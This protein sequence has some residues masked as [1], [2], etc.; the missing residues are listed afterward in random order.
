MRFMDES[1]WNEEKERGLLANIEE[2]KQAERKLEEEY[3]ES[4][5]MSELKEVIVTNKEHVKRGTLIAASDGDEKAIW[6]GLIQIHENS[7]RRRNI[8][9][10]K[11]NYKETGYKNTQNGKKVDKELLN[12]GYSGE[13]Q[14]VTYWKRRN[15]TQEEGK[16]V[17]VVGIADKAKA[18]D[19]WNVFNKAEKVKDIVLPR[20]RDKFGNR[21]GFVKTNS[22]VEAMKINKRMNGTVF[23]GC[24]LITVMANPKAPRR[25]MNSGIKQKVVPVMEK[26]YSNM[27]EQ[28]PTFE[29]NWKQNTIT[30]CKV[31]DTDKKISM[32]GDVDITRVSRPIKIVSKP[33]KICDL[34]HVQELTGLVERS[35]IGYTW[36]HEEVDLL[37]E[38]MINAGFYNI[39]VKQFSGTKFLLS[40]DTQDSKEE[41]D[42]SLLGCW[43]EKIANVNESYLLVPMK[44]WIEIIGLPWTMCSEENIKKLVMG[45]GVLETWSGEMMSCS[46]IQ[47][48]IA[49][50]STYDELPLQELLE[51]CI[52]G[53]TFPVKCKEMGN[54]NWGQNLRMASKGMSKVSDTRSRGHN[55]EFD[56]D[57]NVDDNVDGAED[58]RIEVPMAMDKPINVGD[59]NEPLTEY[60]G[61]PSYLVSWVPEPAK[62]TNSRAQWDH[63][64]NSA[65]DR[66]EDSIDMSEDINTRRDEITGG[67]ERAEPG[68]T[69][70]SEVNV[71]NTIDR[72]DDNIEILGDVNTRRV[73]NTGGVERAEP[74]TNSD[75]DTNEENEEFV[76]TYI[77]DW[78]TQEGILLANIES[79]VSLCKILI[80]MMLGPKYRRRGGGG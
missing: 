45:R 53:K 31:S 68:F 74:D 80:D 18:R 71:E 48:P 40:C 11:N 26:S 73:E 61:D 77:G 52:E 23:L 3:K 19:V 67:V 5:L 49:C 63:M 79:Q 24:K 9:Y 65:V 35:M 39:A 29:Q 34:T 4:K 44:T 33:R 38:K 42:W 72:S 36:T 21:I 28:M 59:I 64:E 12:E 32:E 16:T 30:D 8:S 69:S 66:T 27:G 2:M 47:N 56:E 14:V 7:L 17:Y 46:K 75:S 37:Q 76:S 70:N 13:C 6:E 43:F 22:E 60:S 50:I 58:N 51:V 55:T 78:D 41:M 1:P 20:K 57:V 62:Q 25:K 10:V 54:Q 15:A